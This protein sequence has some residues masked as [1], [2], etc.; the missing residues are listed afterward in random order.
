MTNVARHS[1]AARIRL[2]L[3]AAA[4]RVTVTVADNGRGGARM[5]AGGG[6]AGLSGPGQRARRR[7]L[8][9]R[10]S[11]TTGTCVEAALPCGSS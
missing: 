1:R 5:I 2:R 11:A 9:I 7:A 3:E 8:K 4:G 10:S 6:L